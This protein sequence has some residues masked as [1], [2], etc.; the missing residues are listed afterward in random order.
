M[1]QPRLVVYSIVYSSFKSKET[2]FMQKR[3]PVSDGP[4]GKT[5]PRWDPQ[6]AHS[7]STRL[8]PRLVSSLNSTAPGNASSNDGQP[9]F[10]S[11]L[12]SD[13]KSGLWQAA[14][15]YVPFLSS[16]TYLPLNGAS[17]P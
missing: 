1:R 4:S 15:R 7:T 14:Q 6:R 9:L 12:V 17:V 13:E 8:M 5:C 2:E 11:N 3:C 10:E 16:C